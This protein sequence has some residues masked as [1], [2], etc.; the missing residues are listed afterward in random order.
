[1]NI[2]EQKYNHI[3]ILVAME[4]ELQQLKGLLQNATEAHHDSL[5]FYRG[6][7]GHKQVTLHQC[8]IGKVNAAIGTVEMIR[9]YTPDL[10]I[11][12]GVAGGAQAYMNP[13]DVVVATACTYH[14]AYCGSEAAYGQI[15]GM[16]ERYDAP[17]QVT[18]VAKLL[19]HTAR[20]HC[21]LTVTGDWFVDTQEKMQEI[22]QH[23]PDALAVDMESCAIA[24]VC[25]LYRTPFISFRIISDVPLNDHKANMYYDFWEKVAKDSFDITSQFIHKV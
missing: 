16:P 12:S 1:M 8:G 7:I 20:I 3:A 13:L 6:T 14:D 5:T 23:F 17:R 19:T 4:K 25:H 11:S 2:L 24:Q 18:E 21:G 15:I 10:I 9:R 22:L